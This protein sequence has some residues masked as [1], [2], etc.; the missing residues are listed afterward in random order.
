MYIHACMYIYIYI[1]TNIHTHVYRS[2]VLI[3]MDM[4]LFGVYLTESVTYHLSDKDSYTQFAYQDFGY[5]D[6]FQGLGC[7]ETVF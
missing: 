5:Q 7:L 3:L 4:F 6:L 2:M 1:Y